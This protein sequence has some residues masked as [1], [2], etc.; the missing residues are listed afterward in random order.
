[1]AKNA[2]VYSLGIV[3][4]EI[5]TEKRP[6]ATMINSV[7][8]EAC[9]LKDWVA[10]VLSGGTTGVSDVL[11]EHLVQLGLSALEKRKVAMLLQLASSCC[12]QIPDQRPE[13]NAVLSSLLRTREMSSPEAV[14]TS[15]VQR[16]VV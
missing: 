3:I 13:I 1:M 16:M 8:Q 6:T 14:G 15:K 7:N 9:T 11:D 4:M 10:G 2:D 5:L 12:S